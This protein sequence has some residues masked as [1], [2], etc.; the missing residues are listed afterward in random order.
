MYK[1]AGIT[2]VTIYTVSINK[3]SDKSYLQVKNLCT[4]SPLLFTLI[5]KNL[6]VNYIQSCQCH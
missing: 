2:I 3:K 1:L 6:I 4:S 5:N